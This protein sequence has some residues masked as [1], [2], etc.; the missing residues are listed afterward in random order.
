MLSRHLGFM[1]IQ[2]SDLSPQAVQSICLNTSL[3]NEIPNDQSGEVTHGETLKDSHDIH[4]HGV[5]PS[6]IRLTPSVRF[7]CHG[8]VFASRRTRIEQPQLIRQILQDDG[9]REVNYSDIIP[10]DVV[11][12]IGEDSDIEHSGVVVKAPSNS[13]EVPLVC[14]KWGKG[15]EVIH[16][17]NRCPYNHANV[18]YYRITS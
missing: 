12:Y 17:F 7:N 8:M 6:F 18:K 2:F 15:S 11:L 3:G 10:G 1:A 9:Y 4:S 16:A 13:L 14:S 5:N